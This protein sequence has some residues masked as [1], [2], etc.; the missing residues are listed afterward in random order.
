MLYDL[1]RRD[2]S[3]FDIRRV[4]PSKALGEQKL[5]SLSPTDKWWFDKLVVGG[6]R[7]W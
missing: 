6:I 1:Q 2:L 4:P 3:R 7:I 5:Q